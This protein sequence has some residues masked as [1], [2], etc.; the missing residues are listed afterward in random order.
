MAARGDDLPVLAGRERAQ[1]RLQQ[2]KQTK[3]NRL[4]AARASLLFQRCDSCWNR[5]FLWC[6]SLHHH[7]P[8]GPAE[9]NSQHADKT[10]GIET[11]RCQMPTGVVGQR[12]VLGPVPFPA[13]LTLNRHKCQQTD[14]K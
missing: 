14:V 5:F 10:R 7:R 4:A 11:V 2:A 3:L 6:E 9:A 8:Y 12:R 1:P 13:V